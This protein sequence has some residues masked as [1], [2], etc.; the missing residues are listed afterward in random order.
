MK[1]VIDEISISEEDRIRKESGDLDSLQ[2]SIEQVGLINPV[3]VDE[4]NQL[5]AG[6]RRLTVCKKLG[7]KEIDAKVVEVK[8]DRLKALDIEV[9]E[10]LYRKNFTQEELLAIE[11]R[12]KEI[13]ESLRKKSLFERFWL[14]LKGLFMTDPCRK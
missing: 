5:I 7:W 13:I 10:N 14:W 2:S 1:I 3:L 11:R 6:Y 8:G 9:A 12:R 4:N